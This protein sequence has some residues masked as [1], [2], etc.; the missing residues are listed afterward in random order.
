MATAMLP[1][2]IRLREI[3]AASSS[4]R[5]PPVRSTITPMPANVQV[6]GMSSPTVPTITNVL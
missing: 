1:S 2:T 5:A 4:R 3:G 6:S